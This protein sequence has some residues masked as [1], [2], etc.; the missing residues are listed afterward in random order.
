MFHP[1][2]N[3]RITSLFFLSPIVHFTGK[4]HA[5]DEGKEVSIASVRLVIIPSMY[6]YDMGWIGDRW[7]RLVVSMSGDFGVHQGNDACY[8]KEVSERRESIDKLVR[9]TV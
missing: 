3:T 9:L 8:L 7:C 4:N 1:V 5:F 6:I 2:V